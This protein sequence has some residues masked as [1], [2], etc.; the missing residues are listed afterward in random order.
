MQFLGAVFDSQASWR[1]ADVATVLQRKD[2]LEGVWNTKEIW[3]LRMVWARDLFAVCTSHHWGVKFGLYLVITEHLSKLQIARIAQV[4]VTPPPMFVRTTPP[5]AS[6]TLT[7]L[8]HAHPPCSAGS[9]GRQHGLSTQRPAATT[10]A[11][12]QPF[13]RQGFSGGAA[14]SSIVV[15]VFGRS[16]ATTVYW[17]ERRVRN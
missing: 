6:L 9:A 17:S 14:H 2:L 8:T 15:L 7:D 11:L 12:L 3:E 10:R 16:F 1:A 13:Q 4:F 5:C